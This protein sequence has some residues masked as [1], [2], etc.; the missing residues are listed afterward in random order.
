MYLRTL[1]L[2]GFKS[3]AEKTTLQFDPGVTAI[4]GPNGC[5]KSNVIDAVR[6]VLGEQRAR[7]LRSDKMESVIFNGTSSRRALG[8]AEVSLTI[9]NN[10]GVLPTAYSEV[11]VARRLYRSGD[12]EY[13]LNGTVCR[14]KDILDL[15]MDTGLGAGAYSVIE[16]K[17]IED[18][19]SENAAD[20]RRLF[21]EAA[22]V[23]KYKRRRAQALRKLDGTQADL[24][25]LRDLT[26][27]IEKTVRRLARQA[28]KAERYQRLATRL[29]ALETALIAHDYARLAEERAVVTKQAMQLRAEVG[30]QN[31]A[32]AKG[33]AAVEQARAALITAE[34]ALSEQQQAQYAH[35]ER[36]R[37][38]EAEQRLATERAQNASATLAQLASEA[39]RDATRQASLEQEQTTLTAQQEA[40]EAR[41]AESQAALQAAQSAAETAR[42]TAIEQ[43]T[44]LNEARRAANDAASQAQAAAAALARLQDRR[45]LRQAEADRLDSELTD[46]G[47]QRQTLAADLDA[48]NDRVAEAWATFNTAQAALDGAEAERERLDA[49]IGQA[50]DTLREAR[51]DVAALHTEADLLQSLL[52]TREDLDAPAAF[53]LDDTAWSGEDTFAPQTVADLLACD[54]GDRRALDAAL[55]AWADALVVQTE[56]QAAAAI[57]RLSEADRGRATF[58][59]LDRLPSRGSRD[60]SPTPPGTTPA[61]DVVRVPE[62]GLRA[63][64]RLLLDNVFIA[65]SLDVAEDLRETYPVATLVTR[66]GAWTSVRG[67][68]AGGEEKPRAAALRL[69]RRERLDQITDT[70]AEAE[71]R[72]EKLVAAVARVEGERAA[73]SLAERQAAQREARQTLARAEQQHARHEAAQ[74]S[75]DQRLQR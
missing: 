33:E 37:A 4:V 11:T 5:G 65:D 24:T 52:D 28:K 61:R 32:L 66:D 53:L 6:W 13:L 42:R 62:D 43:R 18:I 1:Q 51:Q 22:G 49:N 68:Y 38:A 64:V 55:G 21:E 26:D 75:L 27:E 45:T 71:A 35:A 72:I 50:K 15:F 25:R 40:A 54:E 74:Q 57:T 47:Q 12:S 69:G 70:L 48:A 16:L 3:F 30:Q 7:L 10:R 17:M 20:R 9:E 60:R 8:L 29:E 34:Q 63:L 39:E 56:A 73:L 23:T 58:V 46:A 44:A 36:L 31:A 19:L 59:V 14:L 41:H 2:H 67:T